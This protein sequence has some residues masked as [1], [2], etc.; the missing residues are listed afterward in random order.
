M[1]KTLLTGAIAAGTLVFLPMLTAESAHALAVS[2]AAATTTQISALQLDGAG[3]SLVSRVS[4]TIGCQISPKTQDF[5]NPPQGPTVNNEAF[6]GFSDWIFDGKIGE[7]GYGSGQGTGTGT[8]NSWNI[9]GEAAASA[10]DILLIFKGGNNPL[11]GYLVSPGTTS[12]TWN[13]PFT[14]DVFNFPGQ[15][16]EQAL[17]HLSVYY[18]QAD[19]VIP[20][21][22]AVLPGLMGMGAA[23]FRKKKQGEEAT[24]EV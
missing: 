14:S 10:G 22:A 1:K 16:S 18:R 12:G 3:S 24:Q 17:S 6:F 15:S 19:Q 9:F 21:P 13:N 11:V 8:G 4:P 23:V 7:A 2:C 5:L 20:T